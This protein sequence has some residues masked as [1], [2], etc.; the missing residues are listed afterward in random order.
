MNLQQVQSKEDVPQ[1]KLSDMNI[2]NLP[3][4]WKVIKLSNQEL[5]VFENGLWT[6]KKEPFIDCSVIRNTNFMNDGSLNLSN[7]AII[8]IEQRQLEKKRLITGDIII[9]RSGGG[10]QQPVGRV[11]FF[12]LT[13]GN[14]CFSNFTTRLRVIDKTAVDPRYL[15][16]YLLYFH[17][18][19]Q[20][21]RLQNHTTGI[22]NLAFEDYKNSLI[23]LPPYTQ[24]RAIVHALQ[25]AQD[26]I[27][28]RRDERKL[29][30]ER[31]TA[32]MEYLFTHG[33][34]GEAIKQTEIGEIPENWQVV[35]LGE[36]ITLHRGYDLPTRDRKPGG[37][38]IISSSGISGMHSEA[39]VSAPGVVTG[40]YGTIGEVFYVEKDFWPLNTTLYVS[41]YRGAIPHFVAY[42]LR[43]LDFNIFNDKSTVPG[44]N[45]NDLHRIKTVLPPP[46]EQQDIVE[47]LSIL[48][49][50]LSALEQ[51]IALLDELFRAFL[52]EL[53]TGR[54]STQPL[55]ELGETHE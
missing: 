9:E 14:Y 45:R 26:A 6:G 11:V 32:L 40:R 2:D 5:F 36:I 4:H 42:L 44:V 16:L 1:E 20:T 31:K 18:S 52:E 43:T 46:D 29:E 7:V 13:E 22:R 27:Q 39:K 33:T 53:M 41:E 3:R 50:K 37:V 19:G 34:H 35:A 54:L 55:I 25:T 15:H 23:P 48:D 21:E 17:Y 47:V 30:R 51:E 38:P 28:A 49:T 10:P 12:D 8:P 24:Q